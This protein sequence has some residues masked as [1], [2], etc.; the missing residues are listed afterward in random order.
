MDDET[1]PP[2]S[3]NLDGADPLRAIHRINGGRVTDLAVAEIERYI[4]EN[5]LQPGHKLPPE[6]IFIEHLGIS[7]SSVR[8]ALRVLTTS[9]RIEVRHGDGTYVAVRRGTDDE[10]TRLFDA[11]EEHALRNLVETRLGIELAASTAAAYRGTEEDFDRL[12]RDL[13]NYEQAIRRDPSYTWEPLSF[14]LAIIEIT[15]NNWLYEVEL[16]LREAWLSLSI[17]LRT[18]VARH[19]EWLAEHRAILASLRSRNVAQVQR[20]VIGHV[21]LERFE[22][23]LAGRHSPDRSTT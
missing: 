7:R 21:S 17:G 20:M 15:G 19:Q 9:G 4:D 8:E 2:R 18:T 5:R 1:T 16:Q 11:T 12:Q 23:D 22:T 10:A 6:R 13:D 3:D 14:E